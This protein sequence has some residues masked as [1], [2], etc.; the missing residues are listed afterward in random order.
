MDGEGREVLFALV[1]PPA[2]FEV[3][4]PDTLKR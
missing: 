1:N 3:R 4:K 2:D